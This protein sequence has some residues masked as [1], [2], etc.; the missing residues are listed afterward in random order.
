[1]DKSCGKGIEK[2]NMKKVFKHDMFDCG[3][4]AFCKKCGY[5]F[6]P[7]VDWQ[8]M[9]KEEAEKRGKEMESM[10]CEE[11][12]K[13]Y[14]VHQGGLDAIEYRK[15]FPPYNTKVGIL[16]FEQWHG[17][18]HIGSSRIRGHWLVKYWP[19]SEVFT[20]GEKYDAIIFQK[21]FWLDYVKAYKGIKILDLCDPEWL[22]TV[23]LTEIIDNCDAVTTSTEVLRDEI[24]KFTDKPVVFI[25]DRQDLNF[26]NIQKKHE[27]KAKMVVW[28]GYS[29]NSKVL[30]M[31]LVVLKKYNLKLKVISDTRPPYMKADKN[32]KYDWSNPKFDFNKEVLEGDIVLMPVD[33]RPRARFKSKN[34][35][36]T[37]WALGMPVATTPDELVRF[38]DPEERKKEAEKRLK[39][40]KEKWSIEKS[41]E[42]FKNLIEKL[43]NAKTR[44]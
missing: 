17:K 36:H 39:E 21:C 42:E 43:K 31:T 25:P 7:L 6:L 40:V 18:Q 9:E 10:T 23:P 16:L 4:L 11:V 13:R 28:F 29:H 1:M 27:G 20:Q 44:R 12:I 33:T 2:K 38:L 35:T 26:H 41:V 19:E 5:T 22:D 15:G 30:D 3:E 8:D 34:K 32:V 37:A 14:G 24:Q